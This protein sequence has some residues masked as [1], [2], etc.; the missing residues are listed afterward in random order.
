MK[1]STRGEAGCDTV[2]GQG[3]LALNRVYNNC[4]ASTFFAAS[5]LF[6]TLIAGCTFN[7]NLEITPKL[8]T[9]PA[10][11]KEPLTVGIYYSPEFS[12]YKHARLYGPHRWIV[13]AGKDSVALFDKLAA[14]SFQNVV[15]LDGLPPFNG[16]E[17]DVDAIIEPDI[18]AFHFRVSF[19]GYT[20]EQG[21]GYRLNI[22]SKEGVPL[23]SRTIFGQET[24]PQSHFYPYGH[25]DYDMQDAAGKILQEFHHLP[26]TLAGVKAR[27]AAS[28]TV[29]LHSLIARADAVDSP[30]QVTDELSI[31]LTEAGIIAVA[32]LVKNEG[33]RSVSVNEGYFRLVL[34]GGRTIASTGISSIPSRL[35]QRS[36]AFE[37]GAALGAPFALLA[38]HSASKE[39]KAKRAAFID[40]LKTKVFGERVLQKGESAEGIVFFVPA[41]G[42]PSFSAADLSIWCFDSGSQSGIR[43]SMPV[44]KLKFTSSA[45]KK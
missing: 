19:E 1:D 7:H 44:A 5:A 13:P 28:T 37:A 10:P 27:E 8:D 26:N 32:V 23:D 43:T 11:A 4:S 3:S 18:T 2:Y 9:L 6:I 39:A 42:T 15:R 34:P 20:A 45:N 14:M 16:K 29:D 40:A 36:Y 17:V 30:L 22:F 12:T 35:E 33:D 31:P 41:E 25:M 24:P 38:A 21:I